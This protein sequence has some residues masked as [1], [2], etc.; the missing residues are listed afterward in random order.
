MS[1]AS[2]D[3]ESSGAGHADLLRMVYGAEVAQVLYVAAKLGLADLMAQGARA[4]GELATETRVDAATLVRL[5]RGLASLGLCVE[6]EG[7]RFALTPLGH[8][9]RLDHPRS[10][11]ARILF[12]TEVL[13]PVWAEM[14]A[15]VRTGASGALTACGMPFYEYLQHDNDRGALFDRTMAD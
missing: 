8:Y 2:A 4:R 6:L 12:N 5:L 15:A 11:H 7:D 1:Q 14:L 9:L 13:A 3:R 10:L